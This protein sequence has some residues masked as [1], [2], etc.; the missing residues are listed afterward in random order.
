MVDRGAGEVSAFT[1]LSREEIAELRA[2][3]AKA[4]S[5][6]WIDDNGYRVR[7]SA[8]ECLFE[9]KHFD[10][11]SGSDSTLA[12]GLRTRA[13]SL[14]SMAESWHELVEALESLMGVSDDSME[15]FEA[16]AE[17]FYRETRMMAPGKDEPAA[18]GGTATYEERQA[19][20]SEWHAKRRT[21][22]REALARARGEA[23][24]NG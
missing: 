11:A 20:W 12:A 24:A 1:P 4:S 17:E 10:A 2:L 6:P 19:T 21:K 14:L 8:G 3:E 5:T 7:N 15:R 16:W 13:P 22:A 23:V 9:T 18:W